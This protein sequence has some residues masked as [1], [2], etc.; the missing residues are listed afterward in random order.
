MEAGRFK[1]RC[2]KCTAEGKARPETLDRRVRCKH[3]D[4]TFRAVP[5][6]GADAPGAAAPR[7]AQPSRDSLRLRIDALEHEVREIRDIG[8]PGPSPVPRYPEP[9]PEPGPEPAGPVGPADADLRAQLVRA[10]EAARE[11]E[12][13]QIAQK[14]AD[15]ETIDELRREVAALR[16][17][18]ERAEVGPSAFEPSAEAPM[19]DNSRPWP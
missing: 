7:V 3:C 9:E 4:H 19:P 12:S 15:A 11:A 10:L 5:I 2:P 6:E 14:V 8:R 18:V 1:I 17:R 13:R 16:E